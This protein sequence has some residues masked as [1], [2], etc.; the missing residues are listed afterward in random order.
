VA[1]SLNNLVNLY[2][3]MGK[4][5]QAEPLSQRSLKIQ[6]SQAGRTTPRSAVH[7]ME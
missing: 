4:Y 5:A 7:G 2:K 1:E 3:A 6:K